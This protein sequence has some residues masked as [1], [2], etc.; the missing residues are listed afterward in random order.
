MTVILKTLRSV[1]I[2]LYLFFIF[3]ILLQACSESPKEETQSPNV[4]NRPIEKA[5]L[6]VTSKNSQDRITKKENIKFENLEQP[7]EHDA[8]LILDRDKLFQTIVG[9]GGALT[10]ASAETFYKLSPENQE[11]ILT[12]FFDKEKGNGYS[13][14]RTNIHSCDF[15][16]GSYTYAEVPG[17]TS[18]KNFTIEHDLKYKAPFIRAAFKK[19]GGDLKLFA[20]PWSPPAWMKSNNDMLQGGKLLPEY[21][22]TWANY[23]V[24]FVQEFEK[25]GIPVWGLTVQNEPMAVQTWESCIFTAAEE[26]DFVKYFLGPALEKS[27]LLRLKLMVWDHNRGLMYQRAKA[28]YD[29]PLASKYVWGT[30]FHWYVGD[31]FDNVRLL[32]DAY[33][34]KELVFTEGTVANFDA[35]RLG[36]WRWG[37]D[38]ARSMINDFNNWTSGWVGWNVILDESGGPNHVGNFCMAPIICNTKTGDLTYLNSFYYLGHFSRFIRPGAKRII[39][40]SNNDHLL[41]TSFINTDGKIAVVV[42]N[43]KDED[44]EFSIWIDNKA[45]KTLSPSHSIVT[46]VL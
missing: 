17:D 23:F 32:H 46:L 22:K 42:L 38:Y 24:R 11:E 44:I 16:S 30:G 15:S 9:I 35:A 25:A 41:A 14:V 39:C 12:A 1:F 31:H 20:S 10:D 19:A 3:I 13:L 4:F 36:E 40:S 18:L 6:Y 37:E 45:A 26:R 34:E 7:N 43:T 29:D 27:G 28:V 5:E 8:I 33:P 2:N 21:N